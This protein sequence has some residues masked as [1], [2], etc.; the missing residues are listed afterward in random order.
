MNGQTK[1]AVDILLA[2]AC[3][4]P[5]RLD[6]LVIHAERVRRAYENEEPDLDTYMKNLESAIWENIFNAREAATIGRLVKD[7]A[8]GTD[9]I[10]VEIHH[11]LKDT[12]DEQ[13]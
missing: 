9:D 8:L 7:I 6:T 1:E 5:G 13:E 11:I 2:A 4:V 12:L 10:I 3:R